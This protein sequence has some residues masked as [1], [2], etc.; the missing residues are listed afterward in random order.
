MVSEKEHN[1][2]TMLYFLLKKR[3]E[4]GN[5]NA[6][7]A[8]K[9]YEENLKATFQS[10]NEKTKE[11]K[12]KPMLMTHERGDSLN[13]NLKT[14]K[15]A[16]VNANPQK[17]DRKQQPQA[18]VPATNPPSDVVIEFKEK[19]TLNSGSPQIPGTLLKRE[20]SKKKSVAAKEES[21]SPQLKCKSAD[22]KGHHPKIGITL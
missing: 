18:P 3:C 15:N 21:Q 7:E 22:T 8:I 19:I 16:E 9:R 5:L 4:R 12:Y 1:K 10:D 2:Y 17:S 14:Q 11:I 20:I 13:L 6:I